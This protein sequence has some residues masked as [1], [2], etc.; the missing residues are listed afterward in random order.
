M[1]ESTG[2][3]VKGICVHGKK[4]AA[5]SLALW[6]GQTHLTVDFPV[7]S[8]F[9]ASFPLDS[10]SF[11]HLPG[12]LQNLPHAVRETEAVALESK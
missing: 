1:G 3:P 5:E 6:F 12:G 7:S 9:V 8:S 4:G 11:S 10:G 2:F